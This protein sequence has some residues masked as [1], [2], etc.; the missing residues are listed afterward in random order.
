MQSEALEQLSFSYRHFTSKKTII[1]DLLDLGWRKYYFPSLG[2]K[3]E[4]SYQC[5]KFM[6]KHMIIQ[7]YSGQ[8]DVTTSVQLKFDIVDADAQFKFVKYHNLSP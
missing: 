2:I 7:L 6:T 5:L 1:S 3:P 8:P 4:V